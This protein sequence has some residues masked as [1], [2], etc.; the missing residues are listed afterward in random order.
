M[1]N[2]EDSSQGYNDDMLGNDDNVIV[3]DKMTECNNNCLW[4]GESTFTDD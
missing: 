1:D 3:M 4:Y 2:D